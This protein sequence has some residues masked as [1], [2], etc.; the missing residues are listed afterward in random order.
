MTRVLIFA[1]GLA[2]YAVFIATFVYAIGFIGN[3]FVPRAID[4]MPTAPVGRA[5]AVDLA[6]LT[7]F[8]VQH[9]LMARPFFKRWW[10]RIVPASAE[11]STYVLFSSLALIVLFATWRPIGG[12]IWHLEGR[13]PRLP[14]RKALSFPGPPRYS[15]A[16]M[17]PTMGYVTAW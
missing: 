16:S 15:K 2:C 12:A 3:L 9:S 7:L 14:A 17:R 5:V 11:R 10:T 8:A 6:L 1:Y 4:S 13:W